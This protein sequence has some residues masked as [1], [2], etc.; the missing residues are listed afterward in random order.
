MG[1]DRGGKKREIK[2]KFIYIYMYIFRERPFPQR[3]SASTFRFI[4][5]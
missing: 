2:I 1:R 4:V 5:L 3:T